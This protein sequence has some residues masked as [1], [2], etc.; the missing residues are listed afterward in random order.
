MKTPNRELRTWVYDKLNGH[1]TNGGVA[2]P[3]GSVLGKTQ[4]SP[5]ILL[6][7]IGLTDYSVKSEYLVKATLEIIVLTRFA[8]ENANYFQVE[9]I[10]NDVVNMLVDKYEDTANFNIVA[11]RFINSQETFEQTDTD[12]VIY[13]TLQIEF[14]I[15]EI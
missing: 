5:Y 12:K 8:D 6:S 4:A 3:I 15:E 14:T 2:V 10:S 11:S 7:N 13:N 1:I 9:D